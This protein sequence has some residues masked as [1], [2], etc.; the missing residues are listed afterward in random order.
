MKKKKTKR[1]SRKDVTERPSR[2]ELIAGLKPI[3]SAAVLVGLVVAAVYG[4]EEIRTHVYAQPQ[5]NPS[6]TVTLAN[7]PDWI[8]QEGWDQRILSSID[9]PAASE[10]NDPR[11][12][13]SLADQFQASG[14]V[15]QVRQVRRL[16]DGT[17]EIESDYRRPIGM[18]LI[19]NYFVPVDS[20]R[21]RLPERYA[22]EHVMAGA[23]WLRIFGVDAH[24]PAVGGVFQGDDAQAAVS[25]ALLLSEQEFAPRITGVDVSNFRGRRNNREHH[26]LVFVS[27]GVDPVSGNLITKPIA[28][29]SAIGE[30]IEEP[31]PEEKLHTI[32]AFLEHGSAQASL[33]DVSVYRTGWIEKPEVAGG[34]LQTANRETPRP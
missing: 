7:T 21:V 3:G 17:G 14:W 33:V 2:E 22:P 13:A 25:L 9:L 16:I 28:W 24:L 18:M 12:L 6:L 15:S 34:I 1:G 27:M 5:F 8:R 30:E 19:D 29:G 26:I 10:V 4:L 11:I 23:G 32:A 31:T 20:E